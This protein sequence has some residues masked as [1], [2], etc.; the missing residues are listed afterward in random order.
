MADPSNEP[1]RQ[2]FTSELDQLRLQVEVMAVRVSEELERMGRVLLTGD[3]ALAEAALA[4][5]DDVDAMLVSLTS[6]CYELIGRQSPVASDLRFLVSVLKMLEEL[7]RVGDLSLRVVKQV[8]DQRLLVAAPTVFT[9]LVAMA[10]VAQDLYR[11]AH[12]AWST[13][14]LEVVAGLGERSEVMDAHYA[15]LI[16]QL[17]VLE[18]PDAT[19]TAVAAVLVGRAIERIADHA[20]IIGERLRYL[21]TA[22]PAFLASEIR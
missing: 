22:D 2:S 11:L 3:E 9:T 17:L 7:E 4:A 18:G 14:D 19:R 1:L 21:L 8:G 16:D 12:E 13:Q 6:R 10:D 20:V 5:D 15:T